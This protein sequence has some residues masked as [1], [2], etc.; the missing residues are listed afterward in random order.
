MAKTPTP[1]YGFNRPDPSDDMSQFEIWLN[2]NWTKIEDVP[3]PPSGS[4]LP[5]SGN[6]KLGDRFFLDTTKSIYILACR[7]ANWG[8]HWRPIQDAISPWLTIPS[9]CLTSSFSDWSLNLV[10][11]NP[12]AIALDNRGKCY[13]RGVIGPTPPGIIAR[14]VTYEIFKP[15]PIGIRP[16]DRGTFMLGH[17]PLS[18]GTDGTQLNSYQGARIFIYNNSSSSP[19]VRT[20]GGSGNPERLHLNGAVQYAVGSG[21]YTIP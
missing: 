11:T 20:F 16:R 2:Q 17:E 5:Q 14:N 8:W 3:A 4:T 1:N 13:W 18:V 7:D 10:P 12:F 15:L 19:S 21:R 9:T 6:Y